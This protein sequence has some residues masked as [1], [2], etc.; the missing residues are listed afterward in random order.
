VTFR[1]GKVFASAANGLAMWRL[2]RT[3]VIVV[4]VGL[5]SVGSCVLNPQPEPPAQDRVVDA[6]AGQGG[7]LSVDGSSGTGGTFGGAGGTGG[8]GT[9]GSGA[10][11]GGGSG[12]TAGE[13]DAQTNDAASDAN[14]DAGDANQEGGGDSAADALQD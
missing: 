12:G 7:T 8:T 2:A 10:V 13:T 5:S 6:A 4:G 1:A 14:L 3:L 9:G 11:S